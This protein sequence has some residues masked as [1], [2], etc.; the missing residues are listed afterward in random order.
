MAR[1][2]HDIDENDIVICLDLDLDFI[3]TYTFGY[4]ASKFWVFI[5]Y[6]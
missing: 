6:M 3:I 5:M 2:Y 4:F 1:G